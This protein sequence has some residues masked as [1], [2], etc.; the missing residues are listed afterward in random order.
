MR[1]RRPTA[2]RPAPD[3]R[4]FTL[5]ELLVVMAIIAVIAS[6]GIPPLFSAI[7]KGPMRQAIS[8]LTEGCQKA[9]MLAILRGQTAELVITG[10]GQLSVG[11]VP[12][13][14]LASNDNGDASGAANA[15]PATAGD[16]SAAS[17]TLPAEVTFSAHLPDSIA[18]EHLVINRRD[19]LEAERQG[20]LDLDAAR[21]RF[22]PNGTCDELSATLLSGLNE[23]RRLT[24]EISTGQTD[25]E[26]LR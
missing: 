18:F 25:V 2:G 20:A 23:E 3:R 4:G 16:V 11:L 12:P 6:I 1:A 15:L 24:L 10:S 13:D 5:I 21:V 9:R 17:Q 22:Y 19:I 8:D 14:Q 7:R 26:V